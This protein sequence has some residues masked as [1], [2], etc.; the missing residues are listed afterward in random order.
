[1]AYVQQVTLKR[2]P[3]SSDRDWQEYGKQVYCRNFEQT[4]EAL[5]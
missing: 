5:I 4:L 1:M 2:F 3:Y